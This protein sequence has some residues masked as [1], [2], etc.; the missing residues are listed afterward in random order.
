MGSF[1]GPLKAV[2]LERAL[3]AIGEGR[4]REEIVAV[5]D[6]EQDEQSG[7]AKPEHPLLNPA[8]RQDGTVAATNSSSISTAPQRLL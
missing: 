8:F 7:K 6:V 2:S 1:Q 4:S 3:A 5:E